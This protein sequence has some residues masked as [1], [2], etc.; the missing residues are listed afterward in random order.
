METAQFP[1]L[2]I[3]GDHS[4]DQEYFPGTCA[5]NPGIGFSRISQNQECR[6]RNIADFPRTR[7]VGTGILPIFSG[8]GMSGQEY[9]S[10]Q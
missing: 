8:P 3:A 10:Q 7:N 2:T 5:R 9:Q 4:W 1:E 6:D